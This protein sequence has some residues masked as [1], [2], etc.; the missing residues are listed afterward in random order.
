M[1]RQTLLFVIKDQVLVYKKWGAVQRPYFFATKATA[2]NIFTPWI[3]CG[4]GGVVNVG[5]VPT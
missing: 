3:T 1:P 5:L 2:Q 4:A